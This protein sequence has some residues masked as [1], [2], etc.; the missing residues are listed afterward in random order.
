[1]DR[2]REWLDDEGVSERVEVGVGWEYATLNDKR[3]ICSAINLGLALAAFSVTS[4]LAIHPGAT[5]ESLFSFAMAK[6]IVVPGH[7]QSR[8]SRGLAV[9]TTNSL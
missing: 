1:M 6:G 5:L 2:I 9:S 3:E 7:L 8:R 4:L